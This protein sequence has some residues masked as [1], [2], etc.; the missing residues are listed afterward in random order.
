MRAA[1][2]ERLKT[3]SFPLLPAKRYEEE[4]CAMRMARRKTGEVRWGGGEKHSL[5]RVSVTK[6][7]SLQPEVPR[8]EASVGATVVTIS[9]LEI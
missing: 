6:S 4:T 2:T 5:S 1:G 9:P 8:E 3:R 7:A